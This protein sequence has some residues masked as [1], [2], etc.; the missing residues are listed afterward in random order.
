MI[1]WLS[2][3]VA[4]FLAYAVWGM[5]NGVVA[6][7]NDPYTGIFLS[8][9]GYLIAGI[10]SLSMVKFK[11]NFSL[12][13]LVSGAGL[14]IATGI[15]GLFFLIALSRGGN[16]NTIVLLTAMYPLGTILL[17]YFLMGTTISITQLVGAVLSIIA[18]ILLSIG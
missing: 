5:L 11:V 9:I 1:I 17:N 6:K 12:T 8:G 2:W 4:A 13:N 14:G 16:P 7:N 15:G 18:I 10:I 3:S